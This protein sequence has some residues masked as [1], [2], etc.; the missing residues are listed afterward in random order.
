MGECQFTNPDE[1]IID[2][3]I[4]GSNWRRT[5]TKLLEKDATLTLDTTLDI[6]RT[7]EVSS[8]QIKGIATDNSTQIDTP[9]CG[10]APSNAANPPRKP[11]GPIIR[12]CGCCGSD[13]IFLSDPC[14]QR[15]DQFVVHVLRKIIGRNVWR[16][17]KPNKKQKNAR[18]GSKH[19]KSSKEKRGPEKHLHN[20]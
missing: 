13:M 15:L 3:L 4:F 20:P 1:H 19:S 10:Q 8:N 5:Q 7:E 18:R 2:A 11:R 12:L 16:S 14:V 6:A 17:W 9:K